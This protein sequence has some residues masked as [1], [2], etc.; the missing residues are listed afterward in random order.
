MKKIWTLALLLCL[1]GCFSSTPNSRFYLLEPAGNI[2]EISDKKINLSVQ[3]IFVPEYVDRPQIVLQKPDS[4]ELNVA[5]FHRWASDLN[6]MLQNTLI[7]DLQK[8]LPQAVIKPLAFGNTPR[9]VI[10]VNIE[11][12]GGWLG[13]EAY[14][15]GSWQILSPRGRLIYE[16]NF[17]QKSQAGKTYDTYVQAQS[18]MWAAVASRIAE[19]VAGFK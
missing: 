13:A 1:G 6:V 5:E 8:A 4:A 11:K 3:D 7:D 15:N 17:N 10:K 19:K 18:R 16:E 14:I 9:Y 12:M 2:G